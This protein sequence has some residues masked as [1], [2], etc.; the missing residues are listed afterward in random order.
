MYPGYD[1]TLQETFLLLEIDFAGRSELAS[2]IPRLAVVQLRLIVEFRKLLLPEAGTD[3]S[4][5]LELRAGDHLQ[6]MKAFEV[7]DFKNIF[8]LSNLDKNSLR[9]RDLQW[10]R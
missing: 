7:S 9:N 1:T 2:V 6:Y 8:F 10:T 4:Q 3:H 5:Q